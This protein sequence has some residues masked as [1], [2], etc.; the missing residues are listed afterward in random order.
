MTLWLTSSATV[1]YT[2]KRMLSA[3]GP[4]K[5]WIGL[6][7]GDDA[8][9]HVDLRAEVLVN[10]VVVPAKMTTSVNFSSVNSSPR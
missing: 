6:K 1:T 3:V 2:V 8:G 5:A 10:G 9:L 7:N 4:V